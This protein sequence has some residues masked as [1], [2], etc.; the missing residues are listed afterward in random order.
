MKYNLNANGYG[1]NYL[2][3]WPFGLESRWLTQRENQIQ[4]FCSVLPEMATH[5]HAKSP[6]GFPNHRA[7]LFGLP[8]VRSLRWRVGNSFPGNRGK[9]HL[10]SSRKGVVQEIRRESG[11]M[12]LSNEAVNSCDLGHYWPG[13]ADP[14]LEG[15][16]YRSTSPKAPKGVTS[17]RH[18]VSKNRTGLRAVLTGLWRFLSRPENPTRCRIVGS[19]EA[20]S[21]N[22]VGK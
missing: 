20:G 12:K 18:K 15:C 22:G 8:P 1:V 13:A 7:P 14:G 10:T 6:R 2:C 9:I 3:C 11:R 21:R 5:S 4:C 17:S 19:P 16:S